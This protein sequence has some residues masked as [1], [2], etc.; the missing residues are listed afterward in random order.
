MAGLLSS[1]QHT[2]SWEFPEAILR[3][4]RF[5]RLT[6]SLCAGE[7]GGEQEKEKEHKQEKRIA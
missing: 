1:N 2:T 5:R 4:D 6:C 3:L 7:R